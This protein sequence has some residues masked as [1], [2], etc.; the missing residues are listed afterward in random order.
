M[1]LSISV[2]TLDINDKGFTLASDSGPLNK[3]HSE[4]G[5]LAGTATGSVNRLGVD[6]WVDP[7]DKQHPTQNKRIASSKQR[8]KVLC[9]LKLVKGGAR[10]VHSGILP[11]TGYGAELGPATA[12]TIRQANTWANSCQAKPI[13]VNRKLVSAV[14]NTYDGEL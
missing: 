6:H 4:L 3:A 1:S 2:L 13:G 7:S 10:L 9:R 8:F 12:S 11:H 5:R 14:S